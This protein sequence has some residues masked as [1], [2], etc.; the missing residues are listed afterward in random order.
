[1]STTTNNNAAIVSE[2][3]SKL[4]KGQFGYTVITTTVPKMTKTDNVFFGRVTK[5]SIYTNA[6]LGC[7][8]ENLVNNR[9]ERAGEERT[10]KTSA[11]KGRKHYNDFFDQSEKESDKFYLRIAFY[12]KQTHV[13]SQYLVDG[14]IATPEQLAAIKPHLPKK[15]APQNQGLNEEQA[16]KMIAVSVE[17]VSGIVQGEKIVYNGTSA[18]GSTN[19]YAAAV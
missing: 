7:S 11:P 13:T 18:E 8:Y 12:E 19:D 16:V 14:V 1:M 17:N 2:I 3:S 9:R 5:V 6:C 4:N 10:F 15:Y